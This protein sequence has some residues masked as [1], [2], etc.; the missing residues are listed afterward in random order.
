MVWEEKNQGKP[1]QLDFG[2][3]EKSCGGPS[4]RLQVTK[5]QETAQRLKFLISDLRPQALMIHTMDSVWDRKWSSY[6]GGK[7]AVKVLDLF[8]KH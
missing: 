5:K 1:K 6:T 2:P 3:Q 4:R 7:W 8:I